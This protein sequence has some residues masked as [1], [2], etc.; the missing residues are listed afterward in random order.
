M[1]QYEKI[2][3]YKRIVQAKLYIDDH[4]GDPID[5]N[6]ISEQA[7]FSKFHFIRVFKSVYGLTPKNYLTR[8]RIDQAKKY[9]SEGH[10]VLESG[11]RVGFERPTT[12]SGLFKKMTGESPS[13]YQKQ[14]L[15]RQQAMS[16][17]PLHF[18]PNCFAET[19]G[20]AKPQ[21]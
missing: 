2:Y 21:D 12:F 16:L 20:W 14:Q 10:S 1:E 6:L 4:F 19:H 11:L 18:V 17:Q 5:L 8:V 15:L 7:H 13:S 9:L 3:L